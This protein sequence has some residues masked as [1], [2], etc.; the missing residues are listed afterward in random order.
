MNTQRWFVLMVAVA[1]ALAA[2]SDS[3]VTTSDEGVTNDESSSAVTQTTA[4]AVATTD[5]PAIGIQGPNAFNSP[6]RINGFAGLSIEEAKS[7]AVEEGWEFIEVRDIDF[8]TPELPADYLESLL[9]LYEEDGVVV[10][11]WSGGFRSTE[12]PA[13]VLSEEDQD[14]DLV[15]SSSSAAAQLICVERSD[16]DDLAEA[17]DATTGLTVDAALR[18]LEVVHPIFEFQ[19]DLLDVPPMTFELDDARAEAL[20]ADGQG[21]KTV[22]VA[23]RRSGESWMTA[24]LTACA[25]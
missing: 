3:S 2:C 11:A 4:A 15:D 1:L 18:E 22:F 20:Y 5:A 16:P 25:R 6:T 23:L 14:G 8:V 7:R 9:G 19:S 24:S 10:E 17:G 12:A 21:R 13:T